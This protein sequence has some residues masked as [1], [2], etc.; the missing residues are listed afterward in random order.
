M[1][2]ESTDLR[3]DQ[4]FLSSVRAIGSQSRFS[5]RQDAVEAV[6]GGGIALVLHTLRDIRSLGIQQVSQLRP[7]FVQYN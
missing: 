3:E 5:H 6:Y 7:Q 4:P 2:D 1:R